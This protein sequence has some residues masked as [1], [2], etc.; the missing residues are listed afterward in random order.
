MFLGLLLEVGFCYAKLSFE[1]LNLAF[2]VYRDVVAVTFLVLF[3]TAEPLFEYFDLCF[4]IRNLRVLRLNLGGLDLHCLFVL[5]EL[6][7]L[8][9]E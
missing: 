4:Q 6:I 9:L 2:I 1:N 7:K 5:V 8:S 3:H